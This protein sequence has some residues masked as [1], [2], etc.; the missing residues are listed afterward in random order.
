M[1]PRTLLLPLLLLCAGLARAD[2][3][4]GD[5]VLREKLERIE[6]AEFTAKVSD[7]PALAAALQQTLRAS[8]GGEAINVLWRP[9]EPALPKTPLEVDLKG[10]RAHAL[11]SAVCRRANLFWGLRDGMVVIDRTPIPGTAWIPVIPFRVGELVSDDCG[12]VPQKRADAT[13]SLLETGLATPGLAAS[14]C[15]PFWNGG[16]PIGV[17]LVNGDEQRLVSARPVSLTMP[18]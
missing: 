8:P 13:G 5:V 12:L 3:P 9:A 2:R 1:K 6:C 16:Q 18:L 14:L 17:P 11:L 15:P 10:L 7:G 4:D